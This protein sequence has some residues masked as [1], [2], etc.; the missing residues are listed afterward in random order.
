MSVPSINELQNRGL[1][2]AYAISLDSNVRDRYIEKIAKIGYVDPYSL[3][4]NRTEIPDNVS[5]GHV[6][7]Y[8]SQH[9]SP[10]TGNHFS[11]TRSLEAY[12][13]FMDGYLNDVTGRKLKE[14]YVVKGKVGSLSLY[15]NY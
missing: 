11:N 4:V 12:K 13:K 9:R 7:N 10:F 1:I 5:T 8:L 2:S 14:H 3:R 15:L 6:V